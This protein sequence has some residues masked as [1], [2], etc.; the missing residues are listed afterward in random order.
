MTAT[1]DAPTVDAPGQSLLLLYDGEC[2]FC[3]SAAGWLGR[4]DRRGALRLAPLQGEAGARYR[5]HAAD[6]PGSGAL[7]TLVVVDRAAAPGELIFVRSAAVA[8]SLR[9]LGLPWS[10]AGVALAL[11]PRRAADL[12]YRA[13]ARL[14]PG[15]RACPA[16]P[17]AG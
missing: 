5:R 17:P 8:R 15:A 6:L 4:Q 9:A 7:D 3:A 10:A 2:G 16:H 12:A 11:V 14:R 13:V 1:A